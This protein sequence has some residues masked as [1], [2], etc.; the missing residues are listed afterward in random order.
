MSVCAGDFDPFTRTEFLGIQ[1]DNPDAGWVRPESCKDPPVGDQVIKRKCFVVYAGETYRLA[2]F[3]KRDPASP[4]GIEHQLHHIITQHQ[5]IAEDGK[6]GTAWYIRPSVGA[7]GEQHRKNSGKQ[8]G[9][10]LLSFS[11]GSL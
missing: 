9:F 3:P 2:V 5:A 7:A 4:V 11:M 8:I 10:H 1:V 6:L